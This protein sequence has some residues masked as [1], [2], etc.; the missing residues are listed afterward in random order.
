MDLK[1]LDGYGELAYRLGRLYWFYYDDYN[2][3]EEG[4]VLS[5][6]WF[7]DAINKGYNVK[8]SSIYYDLGIFERDIA[9][10][11]KDSSDAGMYKA[12]WDNLLKAQEE[13]SNDVVT[14]QIY[15]SV[16]E[17]ISVYSYNL[18]K[19]GVSYEEAMKEVKVLQYFVDNYAEEI[20][21][22]DLQ[23]ID[24]YYYWKD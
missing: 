1:E 4:K 12:Y 22:W 7:N 3:Q 8:E 9:K 16:S 20:W 17:C 18:K 24:M 13:A 2:E 19:D 11:I 21:D 15:I 5:V 10:S 14:M 23:Y 6:K